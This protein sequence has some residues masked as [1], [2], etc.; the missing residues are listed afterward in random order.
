MNQIFNL[1]LE[2]RGRPGHAL[3]GPSRDDFTEARHEVPDDQLLFVRLAG[4]AAHVW[5]R[6]NGR[7]DATFEIRL[8]GHKIADVSELGVV[9]TGFDVDENTNVA[10]PVK[11]ILTRDGAGW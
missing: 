9:V 3:V 4:H 6:P 7:D 8:I 10:T 2:R 1:V 5:C 11:L